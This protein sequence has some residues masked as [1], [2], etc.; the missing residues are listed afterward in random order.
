M[1]MDPPPPLRGRRILI[2]ESNT[3]LL[4]QL[5]DV[6]ENSEG[7]ETFYVKDPHGEEGVVRRLTRYVA[8]AAIINSVHGAVAKMLDVPVL[9]YGANTS[10]PAEAGAIARALNGM[11]VG[12]P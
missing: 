8:C 11:L 2:V 12:R 6:L 4:Y 9:V 1:D 5:M 3:K 10:V 7:A